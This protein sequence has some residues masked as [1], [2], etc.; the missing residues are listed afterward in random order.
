MMN[1]ERVVTSESQIPEGWVSM[2]SFEYPLYDRV[3][4]GVKRGKLDALCLYPEGKI[5]GHPRKWVRSEQVD[6]YLG[7]LKT[8]RS[9]RMMQAEKADRATQKPV[10]TTLQSEEVVAVRMIAGKQLG[11]LIAS[12][13]LLTMA[14][15]DAATLLGKRIESLTEIR[16]ETVQTSEFN[17][18]GL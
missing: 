3:K 12:I 17:P 9:R 15:Q 16:G 5:V 14:V 13:D 6:Q 7:R 8:R 1:R 10:T 4:R 18:S 2:R 11:D